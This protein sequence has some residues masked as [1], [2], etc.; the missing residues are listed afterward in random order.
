MFFLYYKKHSLKEEI[1]NFPPCSP[2]MKGKYFDFFW[3]GWIPENN[4]HVDDNLVTFCLSIAFYQVLTLWSS[5]EKIPR[6][7]PRKSSYPPPYLWFDPNSPPQP[8][9][10]KEE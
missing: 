3:G 6:K 1:S 5:S 9:K 10:T 7:G 2:C 4:V 8:S